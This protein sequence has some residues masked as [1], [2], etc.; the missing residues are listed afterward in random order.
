MNK[1]GFC[2]GRRRQMLLDERGISLATSI[3]ALAFLT[4]LVG[5]A[6][7]FTSA[8]ERSARYSKSASNASALAEAG[9][10]ESIAKIA[11]NP[12]KNRDLSATSVYPGGVVSTTVEYAPGQWT[13]D[14]SARVR[15][16]G[17]PNL[18]DVR[19]K[20]G[21]VVPFPGRFAFTT[22]RNG[23]DDIYVR[24][25]DG[26]EWPLAAN[27]S[28]SERYPQWSPDGTKIAYEVAGCPAS[29]WVVDVATRSARK[30][31]DDAM[32]PHWSPDGSKLTFTR[33]DDATSNYDI[34]V[35]DVNGAAGSEQNVTAT[36][37][38]DEIWSEFDPTRSNVVAYWNRTTNGIVSRNVV[39]RAATV[40]TPAGGKWPT[41]SPD[42]RYIAFADA[43]EIK[44]A[45]VSNGSVTTLTTDGLG[46]D[47]QPA[48]SPD[49]AEQKLLFASDRGGD[50]NVFL[51]P[52]AGV[53]GADGWLAQMTT[54]GANDGEPDWYPL[55]DMRV[56]PRDYR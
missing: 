40:I 7:G 24:D 43:G 4:V 50:R 14:A 48:W 22:D 18:E 16:P 46:N 30:V 15:N 27:P 1:G 9:L 29:V 11:Q 28:A 6:L 19:E 13:L 26:R 54:N 53:A 10:A 44:V 56:Q 47:V 37:T 21:A 20:R 41:W 52:D 49:T 32:Y 42:G 25:G 33:L 12:Y 36:P 45:R 34:W 35:R 5:T 55:D 23:N 31:I 8:N 3:V 38:V 39:T 51:M 17:G 2:V